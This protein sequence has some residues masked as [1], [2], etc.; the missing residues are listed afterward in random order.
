MCSSAFVHY[1]VTLRDLL[2][3]NLLEAGE[4]VFFKNETAT[5]CKNGNLFYF[6]KEYTSLSNWAKEVAESHGLSKHYNGWKVVYVKRFNRPLYQYREKYISEKSGI[7]YRFPPLETRKRKRASCLLDFI[8]NDESKNTMKESFDST[9]NEN[10]DEERSESITKSLDCNSSDTS[11]DSFEKKICHS[12]CYV[13]NRLTG[14]F[15][16]S[17]TTWSDILQVVLYSLSQIHKGRAFFSLGEDIYTFIDEHWDVLCSKPKNSSWRQTAKMTLS[18]NRY[19]DLFENGYDT[20]MTTGFWRLKTIKSSAFSHVDFDERLLKSVKRKSNE[21][22]KKNKISGVS[23]GKDHIKSEKS[24]TIA[25]NVLLG[26][27][28]FASEKNVKKYENNT[29]AD[30]VTLT[31][32][33]P[34][35]KSSGND[36]T[37]IQNSLVNFRY[38]T[39][40]RSNEEPKRTFIHTP[41]SE[42]DR[43]LSL[44]EQIS[45]LE[46]Q[47]QEERKL[48]MMDHIRA[49]NTIRELQMSYLSNQESND[50][51]RKSVV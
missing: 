20:L 40:N 1:N 17:F 35:Y 19:S 2:E 29:K 12:E 4:E 37:N 45:S 51:D 32:L 16:T 43:I 39:S 3:S 26:V 24:T 46:K 23:N 7:Q 14:S 11:L 34:I 9:S 28:N 33:S 18:H 27:K 13:C 44:L 31:T 25:A 30:I 21:R 42:S 5:L 6:G 8:S 22:T 41:V 47:V 50:G 36:I 10:S 49:Y 15:L 38:D 48:R